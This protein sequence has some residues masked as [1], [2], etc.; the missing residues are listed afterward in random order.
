MNIL[1]VEDNK[2]KLNQIKSF[3]Q[4]C[5]PNCIIEESS[6]FKDGVNKVYKNKWDLVILDMTL[7]TYTVTHT[8]NGGV[9]KPVGGEDIM[10]RML[11]R[12]VIAPVIVITQFETFDGGRISLRSLNEKF[13][14]EYSEIWKGTVFYE[15][16]DW[17]ISFKELL[18]KLEF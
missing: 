7:P 11:N 15:S 13:E 16:D 9:Q 10:K 8:E 5:Y 1:I 17:R 14:K 6:S 4:E 18:D 12:H 2:N 3:L